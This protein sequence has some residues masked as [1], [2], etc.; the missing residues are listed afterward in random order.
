MRISASGRLGALGL[1]FAG[2]WFGALVPFHPNIL[3]GSVAR[4]VLDDPLWR[5]SH[6]A[7]FLTGLG[8]IFGAAA[9]L[10]VLRG[11]AGRVEALLLGTT[12]LAGVSAAATGLVEA[13][14]FPLLAER[15]PD[16]LTFD[17]QLFLSPWF[18]LLSGPWLL[19]PL[20]LAAF[21]ALAY[22]SGAHRNAGAALAVS[23]VA[24]F[25]PGMWFVPVIGPITC[26]A[27]GA[28]LVWWAAIVWRASPA[29][30]ADLS[31]SPGARGAPLPQ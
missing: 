29:D 24:F 22:R 18:A 31:R 10:S 15:A 30:E 16:V 23:G 12:V 13:A 11:R 14:A 25:G 4:D 3:T 17:S 19:L 27:F 21:G 7:M 9:L 26:V 2:L 8:S 6:T 1:A 5:V 20:C 28:A